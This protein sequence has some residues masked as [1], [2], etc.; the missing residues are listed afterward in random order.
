MINNEWEMIHRDSDSKVYVS[1]LKV[2]NGW[3]V[4][5]FQTAPG[6]S[7]LMSTCFILDEHHVWRI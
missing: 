1:R 2:F 3:I 7:F 5:T 4:K 6:A